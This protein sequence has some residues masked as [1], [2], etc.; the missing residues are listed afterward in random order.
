MK[1]YNAVEHNSVI[2]FSIA[3]H[4]RVILRGEHPDYVHAVFAHV[5]YLMMLLHLQYDSVYLCNSLLSRVQNDNIMSNSS[6]TH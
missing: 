6:K 1:I 5:S 4:F 2:F 3:D